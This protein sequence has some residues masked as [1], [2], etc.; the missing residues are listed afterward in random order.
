MAWEEETWHTP[1]T[2][3]WIPVLWTVQ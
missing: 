3:S 1:W 2:D